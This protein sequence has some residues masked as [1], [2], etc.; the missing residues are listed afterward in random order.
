M[1]FSMG[2]G[3]V[4][5]PASGQLFVVTPESKVSAIAIGTGETLWTSSR[6]AKPLAIV[7]NKLV[8]QLVALSS[9]QNMVLARFDIDG[10]IISQDSITL[11]TGV[12]SNLGQ[13]A[14]DLFRIRAKAIGNLTYVSW[15]Y[16]Q[17]SLKGIR[18]K[19]SL[20]QRSGA[21]EFNANTRQINTI[22]R[23]SLPAIFS[24]TIV[25]LANQR[26]IGKENSEQQFLSG[27]KK[28]ILVS[29]KTA[30]NDTFNNYVWEIYN[31]NSKQKIGE[32]NT[33]RSYAPFF[34][35]GNT[36]VYEDG[37]Y[38]RRSNNGIIEVP[39]QLVAVNLQNGTELWKS[40]ILD[41]TYRG[42]TPP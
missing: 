29:R 19:D 33:Y 22:T 23:E 7:D 8:C 35:S 5:N 10:S 12:K 28:H 40:V 25:P 11:P 42:P 4:V 18:E 9:A 36:F 31:A 17:K 24:E 30:T 3:A 1:P 2:D 38:S 16:E 20:G 39:R 21:L 14:T 13:T 37:P 26:I 6:S 27:D 15:T 32:I 34:I 41:T